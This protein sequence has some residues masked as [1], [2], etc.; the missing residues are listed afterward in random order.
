MI[1]I[2]FAGNARYECVAR[3]L[4]GESRYQEKVRWQGGRSD[5]GGREAAYVQ[6]ESVAGIDGRVG[7]EDFAREKS[8]HQP[9]QGT[10][11]TGQTDFFARLLEVRLIAFIAGLPD[12]VEAGVIY[13]VA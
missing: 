1:E 13:V 4:T 10:V 8:A 11:L 7:G 6:I 3:R 12:D 2:L 9:I 5:R